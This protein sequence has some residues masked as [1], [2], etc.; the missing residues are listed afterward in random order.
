M[1]TSLVGLLQFPRVWVHRKWGQTMSASQEFFD[2]YQ[3]W[4][5]I[6]PHERPISFYRLL[7]LS[8]FESDP[9]IIESA[10]EQRLALLRSKMTGPY[11]AYAE[12]LAAQVSLA[13]QTLLDPAR[14]STYDQALRGQLGTPPGGVLGT[15]PP[16]PGAGSS[17]TTWPTG[18]GD[19]AWRHS[20]LA[21]KKRKGPAPEWIAAMIALGVTAICAAVLIIWL[22]MTGSRGTSE[23]AGDFRVK[24][25]DAGQAANAAEGEKRDQAGAGGAVAKP[26]PA[27]NAGQ[28]GPAGAMPPPILPVQPPREEPEPP[29]IPPGQA[30][31]GE[32]PAGLPAQFAKLPWLQ[33][34]EQATV[35]V[36]GTNAQGSGFFVANRLGKRYVVTNAH[37]VENNSDLKIRL[38]TGQEM[39]I[40]MGQVLP[41]YDLAILDVQGLGLP[42]PLEL[43]DNPPEVGEKVYA[44]GAPRGLAGSLTEGIVSAIRTTQEIREAV[45]DDSF[46]QPVRKAEAKW[47]Q[48]TAPI[49]PGNSGGPLLDGEGRVVGMNTAGFNALLAQNLNFALASPEIAQQIQNPQLAFL[50]LRPQRPQVPE[51]AGGVPQWP[52]GPQVPQM[53]V[54]FANTGTGFPFETYSCPDVALPSGAVFQAGKIRPPGDW[55]TIIQDRPIFC[56]RHGSFRIHRDD[57]SLSAKSSPHPFYTYYDD[58][59]R[60]QFAA[61]FFKGLLHGPLVLFAEGKPYVMANYREGTRTGP[62]IVFDENCYPFFMVEFTRNRKHGLVCVFDENDPHWPR[63]MENW[64]ANQLV[65][66]CYITWMGERPLV[67][68]VS[69]LNDPEAQAKARQ[70]A[71]IVQSE[72]DKIEKLEAAIK[73]EVVE[74]FRQVD[75]AIKKSRAAELGPAARDAILARHAARE[76]AGAAVRAEANARFQAGVGPP[77]P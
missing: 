73:A 22:T 27:D 24:N 1:T 46:D 45:A 15:P 68:L 62:L 8:P 44:Y 33:R 71:A 32:P 48:T 29:A 14:K 41:E 31:P 3:V 70:Y 17:G 37:V 23:Q 43:C 16:L 55:L 53:P 10:A 67:T 66:A 18:M 21:R 52:V 36:Q 7:G 56:H 49:S 13:R 26:V 2:P 64:R 77:T 75:Q 34:V 69:A 25:A 59:D 11:A 39:P 58:N 51:L 76:A 5:G 40:R 74:V 47:V 54:P 63:Y 72:L 42:N 6:P 50:P 65:E 9:Q 19:P 38:K 35:L 20:G 60:L 12:Q 28:E 4:L 30:P 61:G 57:P